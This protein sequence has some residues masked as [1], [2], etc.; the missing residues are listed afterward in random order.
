MYVAAAMERQWKEPNAQNTMR[1][2]VHRVQQDSERSMANAQPTNANVQMVHLSIKLRV[3]PTT[4]TNV[5]HA[6]K[7]T[8]RQAI[9][10]KR[11]SSAHAKME[12]LLMETLVQPREVWCAPHAI[13]DSIWVMTKRAKR[14]CVAAAM[15]RQWKEPNAQSTMRKHVHRA[16]Q[17]TDCSMMPNVQRISVNV[18]MAKHYLFVQHTT[19]QSASLATAVSAYLKPHVR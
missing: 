8:Q 3:F 9:H 12:M 4:Q 13:L 10:A 15:E 18:R 16:K 14:M 6:M 19:A 17:D 5:Q 7:V 1:K 11:S 2:H